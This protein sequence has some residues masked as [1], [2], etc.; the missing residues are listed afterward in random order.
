MKQK[1][2]WLVAVS[3]F[4]V[5]LVAQHVLTSQK[6][7]SELFQLNS[8]LELSSIVLAVGAVS[9]V[10][11]LLIAIIPYKKQAYSIKFMHTLPFSASLVSFAL[12]C[13]FG[14][15]YWH[16]KKA[17]IQFPDASY[18]NVTIPD[19]LDCASVHNGKFKMEGYKLEREGSRQVHTD[20]A[21]GEEIHY[22]IEWLND[23][24]Y[25]LISEKDDKEPTFVKILAV[26]SISYT[27]Y[28]KRISQK[29]T[30]WLIYDKNPG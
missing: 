9:V 2:L 15:Y 22:T 6:S 29:Q 27:C 11:G 1:I 5:F 17:G 12:I 14:F 18:D 8:L 23:C 7:S 4:L 26:D 20:I 19:N 10:L 16:L 28:V 30:I 21:T 25:K 13:V 24:E 3:L